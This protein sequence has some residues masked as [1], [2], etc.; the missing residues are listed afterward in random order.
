MIS[1]LLTCN[2]EKYEAAQAMKQKL[3][4]FGYGSDSDVNEATSEEEYEHKSEDDEESE[5]EEWSS[6]E[7]EEEYSAEEDEGFFN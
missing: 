4:Q 1:T 7:E 2:L 5:I 6:S 3:A